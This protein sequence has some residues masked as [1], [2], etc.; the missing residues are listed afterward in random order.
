MEKYKE[1]M[2]DK[3]LL[4]FKGI[5]MGIC[6]LIP[7]ISGGTIAFIT[8]IY[9]RLINAVKAFSPKAFYDFFQYAIVRDKNRLNI[10]KQDIKNLDLG[11]LFV[12]FSGIATSIFSG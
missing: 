12:L 10:L 2:K 11:F 6:D 4:F 8:G 5:L 3:I 1:I 9:T 7:G